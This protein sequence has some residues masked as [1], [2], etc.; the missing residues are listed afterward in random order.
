MWGSLKVYSLIERYRDETSQGIHK[1]AAQCGSPRCRVQEADRTSLRDLNKCRSTLP[2]Y[3]RIS[4][5]AC[6]TGSPFSA[7]LRIW[8]SLNFGDSY[9]EG[10]V[11]CGP[12]Y[13]CFSWV[14]EEAASSKEGCW[15][16]VLCLLH[17]QWSRSQRHAVKKRESMAGVLL[18]MMNM[19]INILHHLVYCITIIHS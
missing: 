4:S 14:S 13:L 16:R 2:R 5:N 1:S 11:A 8:T 6:D 10:I 19:C 9:C 15:C 17:P 12:L 18:L 3:M 7:N